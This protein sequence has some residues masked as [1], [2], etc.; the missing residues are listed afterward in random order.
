VTTTWADASAKRASELADMLAKD[1]AG[2]FVT[3][4]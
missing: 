1:T 4:D 2:Q 3:P